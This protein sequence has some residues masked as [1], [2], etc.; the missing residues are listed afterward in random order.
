MPNDGAA[1]DAGRRRQAQAGRQPG[2]VVPAVL[3]VTLL[4]YLFL[5]WAVPYSTTDDLQW[6]MEQGVRWW[7]YG[8]LNGRYV[9]NLVTLLMCHFQPLKVLIMGGCMFAIPMLMAVLMARGDRERFLPVFLLSNALILLMPDIMWTEMYGWVS[10]FGNYGVSAAVFLAFLL[11]VRQTHR[12]RDHLKARA[13]ALFAAALVMGLFVETQ[14]LLFLGVTLVLGL[15]A[16]LWDKPLRLPFW[17]SF[18]GAVLAAAIMFS[19]TIVSDLASSGAALNGLRKLTF[20]AQAGLP[21]MAAGI[22]KWYLHRLLPIALLRGP[23]MAVPMAIIIALGFWNSSLRPLSLLAA[24][25]LWAHYLIWSTNDYLTYSHA[26][27][28]CLSWGLTFLALLVCRSGRELKLRRVLLFLVAPLD[29]LPLAATTTLGHRFYFLPM[30]VL[31][32]LAGDLASPL[33]TRRTGTVLAGAAMACLFLLW[34]HRA[35]VVAGC[36]L[37][38]AQEIRQA[39][40]AGADTL[41]LPTDRYG[42]KFWQARNPPDAEYACYFRWFYGIP[43]DVTLIFLPGGS[44]ETWP[45]YT[46]AQWEQRT[47]MPPYSGEFVS[48]LP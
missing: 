36:S 40:A 24:V 18:A 28:G 31:I 39:A 45:D 41:T 46:Q 16:A 42:D 35:G 7:R 4:F 13:G 29:L 43:E 37:A 34:G 9:G 8:L 25:P 48:S 2:W 20:D 47:E 26:A 14:A 38:R 44:Y 12:R 17:A 11:L 3:A 33:L 27:A 6:G 23:H 19:N 5:A 22:L 1:M 30:L 10:G 32:L 15:Y 21:G